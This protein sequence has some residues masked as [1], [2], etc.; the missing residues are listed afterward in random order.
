MPGDLP[1]PP[2]YVCQVA[3]FNMF[4]TTSPH[5]K[6]EIRKTH[7][8]SNTSITIILME[9][10]NRE[11]TVLKFLFHFI[12][13]LKFTLPFSM[14]TLALILMILFY[15]FDQSTLSFCLI[16]LQVCVKAVFASL[17]SQPISLIF[18]VHAFQ[19]IKRCVICKKFIYES[20]LKKIKLIYFF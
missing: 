20:W 13:L 11:K 1:P 12:C 7:K 17:Y 15:L 16:S 6:W 2:E 4:S 10:V 18:R 14:D 9:A 8:T 3:S 19:T 5:R